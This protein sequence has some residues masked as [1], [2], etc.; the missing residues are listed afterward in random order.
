M[1]RPK[2]E[3]T[4]LPPIWEAPDELWAMIALILTE[5]TRRSAG[6]SG[7]TGARR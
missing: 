5:H 4:L 3:R 2:K 1:S 7:S 6:R